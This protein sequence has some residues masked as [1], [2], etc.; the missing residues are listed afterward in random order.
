MKTLIIYATKNGATK[1]I[2]EAIAGYMGNATLHDINSAGSVSIGSYDCIILGSPLTA[3]QV[4]KSIKSFAVKHTNELQNKKLGI[5]LSGLQADGE[6]EYLKQNFSKEL[7]DKADAK[8]CLGG[9]FDPEKCGFFARTIIK[10]V[11]KLDTYTSTIDEGKIVLF[12]K[13]LLSEN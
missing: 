11:S 13:A 12:A 8:A 2:A 9:I 7:L 10:A 5:F 6:D 4:H 3:G 1:K